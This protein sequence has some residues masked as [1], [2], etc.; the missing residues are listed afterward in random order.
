[1]GSD[2]REMSEQGFCRGMENYARHLA[3][4]APGE[5]PATLLDYLP[6][7]WLLFVDESHITVS[8][9]G[10]MYAGDRARKSTLVKR[11]GMLKAARLFGG[12]NPPCQAPGG[13]LPDGRAA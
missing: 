7:D 8:Q 10:A 6:E 1:M 3:G 2:L 4:R 11:R 13:R 12:P 5:P 9:I